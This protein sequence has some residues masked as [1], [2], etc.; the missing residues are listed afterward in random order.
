MSLELFARGRPVTRTSW[1]GF[2]PGF[3]QVGA[4]AGTVLVP[5][6]APGQPL[7]T[8]GGQI[9]VRVE[10]DT[11]PGE[12]LAGLWDEALWDESHWGSDDPSWVDFTSYVLGV[13][14][15][16]G[17]ERWGERVN[18][19]TASVTV[20]N[21]T[22]IFT[23]ESGVDDPWFR[24]FRPGRRMRIVAIPDPETGVRVPLF[25]GRLDAVYGNAAEAGYDLTSVLEVVDFM[26][27]WNGYDPLETTAT[28]AQRTDL[29]VHAALNRY[30]WPADERDIQT[31]FHNVQTSTL[32]ETTLEE[33]QTAADAE[34]GVFYCSKDGL[35][36]FKNRDWL[37]TDTRSTTVQG[38]SA[39]RKY[40]LE[41]R[42]PTS[43]QSFGHV[44][45][46]GPD[47]QPCRL[48]PGRWHCPRV[49]RPW[50]SERLRASARTSGPTF[51]TRPTPK[52]SHWQYGSS[53]RTRICDHE[54]TR[55]R[56]APSTIPTTKT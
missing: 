30:G 7:Y 51:R 2:G 9:D 1:G 33:C 23:P 22:G 15:S 40:P 55:S 8:F 10:V 42:L 41:P 49:S 26:G 36:V 43:I 19:G 28:G 24:T 35:A 31:G 6:R 48:R 16:Q 12:G 53:T 4:N 29:R 45:G 52:S 56:S 47:N 39:M 50:K 14:T 5:V 21:H 25:T 13:S 46:A 38:I 3:F 20:D 37:T 18:T 17:A 27:D 11:G 54:P 34:G 32:S 44:V